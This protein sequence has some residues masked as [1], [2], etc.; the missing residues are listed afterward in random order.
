ML[1]HNQSACL[2]LRM[3]SL[4]QQSALCIA[5]TVYLHLVLRSAQDDGLRF[6]AEDSQPPPIAEV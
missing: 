3:N 6:A 4:A 5:E 1:Y 2:T